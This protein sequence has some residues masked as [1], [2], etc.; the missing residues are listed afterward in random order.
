MGLKALI[1]SVDDLPEGMKDFY[2]Q[3]GDKFILDVDDI[4]SHPKV[5]GVITANRENKTKRDALRAELDGFKDK[6]S[7]LPEDFDADALD[8]LKQAAE[9]KGGQPS[10]EQISEL[11]T[12]TAEKLEK[13]YLP[14]IQT[15]EEKLGKLH[16]AIQRM[17]IDDGLSR[18]M[19]EASIDP[20][21]K[22]KLLPYLKTRGKIQVE[23]DGDT[24]KAV[25]DTDMGAVSLSQFVSEWAGSDDGKIYV[26]KS[27][28]PDAKGGKGGGNSTTIKRSV[29]DGMSHLERAE[30][31]KAGKKVVDD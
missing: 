19:D 15:R 9:G 27:T 29:W 20:M 16:G 4:D 1:E 7:W 14:E 10:E 12:K 2:K 30:A 3:D 5:R 8:T 25:V 17:T 24:F 18:A 28:G 31:S 22:S 21:H 23:E 11:R 13:K 6:Y 26:A